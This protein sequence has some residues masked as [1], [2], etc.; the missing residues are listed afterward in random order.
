MAKGAV[1]EMRKEGVKAGLFRPISLWPFPI[2]LLLGLLPR[3]RGILVVEA[4]N[5]PLEDELRLALSHAGVH[6]PPP[7]TNLRRFG[8]I[9]PQQQEVVDKL[10][11]LVEVKS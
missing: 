5:G 9:L 7:V 1:E 3:A 4:G 2:D 10:S 11:S 6:T 8:G